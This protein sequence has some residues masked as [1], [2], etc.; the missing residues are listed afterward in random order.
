MLV[1]F[2]R[3]TWALLVVDVGVLLALTLVV[4]QKLVKVPHLVKEPMS[5]RVCAKFVLHQWCHNG[6]VGSLKGH[7]QDSRLHAEYSQWV[8]HVEFARCGAK[9]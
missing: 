5:S 9:R 1:S 8:T 7:A 6:P 2:A 3:Y 4:G